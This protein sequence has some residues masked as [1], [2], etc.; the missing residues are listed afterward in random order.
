LD[1]L[2]TFL[3][4]YYPSRSRRSIPNPSAVEQ[5]PLSVYPPVSSVPAGYAPR[6]GGIGRSLQTMTPTQ[7]RTVSAECRCL[8]DLFGYEVQGS[9]SF[10]V[11]GGGGKGGSSGAK[12][13][14]TL[15]SAG[16]APSIK[17]ELGL[18]GGKGQKGK[19]KKWRHEQE[20]AEEAAAAA[21]A[22][23]G[24]KGKGGK[25]KKGGRGLE[26][27]PAPPDVAVKGK[28]AKL[29]GKVADRAAPALV[30]PPAPPAPVAS[31]ACGSSGA[32]PSGAMTFTIACKDS[33]FVTQNNAILQQLLQSHPCS[34]GIPT[35]G[36]MVN[37][38]NISP[39]DLERECI[40]AQAAE[41][42]AQEVCPPP[43]LHYLQRTLLVRDENSNNRGCDLY[44]R[45][46]YNI[47]HMYTN[48]DKD[49]LPCTSR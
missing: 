37:D 41:P 14:P 35:A 26:E 20:E 13:D 23:A 44:G 24:S 1:A 16:E 4:P 19:G 27:Q 38:V 32:A 17:E 45:N 49:P 22:A 18:K 10:S 3:A 40:R 43:V 8:L 5:S 28:G 34:G 7:I 42:G 36:L 47:R 29:R 48:D 25:G 46:I 2:L 15:E 12:A 21:A 31:T 11:A 9:R 30:A 33:D 39:D 6:Q